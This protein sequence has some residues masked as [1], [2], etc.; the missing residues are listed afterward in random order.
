NDPDTPPFHFA[1]QMLAQLVVETAQDIFT[2]IDQRN[3]RAEPGENVGKLD[4]DITAALNHDALGQIFQEKRLVRGYDVLE[5]GNFG[6]VE[7]RSA[8]RGQERF[9]A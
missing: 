6:A 2:A 1:A 7:W 8:G 9:G 5:T 4:R 3:L